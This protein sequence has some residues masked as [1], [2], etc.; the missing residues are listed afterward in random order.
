MLTKGLW[1]HGVTGWYGSARAFLTSVIL[2]GASGSREQASFAD[3]LIAIHRLLLALV[4]LVN[5]PHHLDDVAFAESEVSENSGIDIRQ[6]AFVHIVFVEDLGVSFA[7][8]DSD[9]ASEEEV[10]PIV[11]RL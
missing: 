3:G 6:H 7:E 9:V 2:Q 5:V 10:E 8:A 11:L 1:I 4:L